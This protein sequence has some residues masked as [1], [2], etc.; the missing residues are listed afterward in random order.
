MDA[1]RRAVIAAKAAGAFEPVILEDIPAAQ[2]AATWASAEVLVCTG[3]G[4]ELPADQA[5][6]APRLRMIQALVAG[7][8]H[9][10]FDRLPRTAIVCSNA[11]AYNAS[12][13]EH[14]MALLL[15]AA[16]DIPART[17]EIRRGLFDQDVMN[18]ALAG[19]TALVLGM[20]GVGTE[21]ARRCKGFQ[22]RVVGIGRSAKESSVADQVGRLRDVPRLLPTADFVVLA[23][24]LTRETIGL[25]DRTFLASM[26]P[27]AVLVNVARG[28]LVVEDDLFDHLRTHP[29]FRAALDVWWTYPDS[30]RGRPFHRPFHELSNVV[31]TP[32]IAW[33]IP[34]QRREAMEAALDNVLRFLRGD[35]PRN[36]VQPEEYATPAMKEGSR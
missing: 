25:V 6:R 11:G 24:P 9:L 7:V 31:M 10:P 8:D 29:A 5:S 16:K 17:D 35:S 14:A 21:V 28:K 3:F 30:K 12:V 32:H 19:S 36:V 4:S 33:A 18:K 20:G 26:K 2:R 27:D 1:D 13:A 34:S 23:L 22:M 15:A